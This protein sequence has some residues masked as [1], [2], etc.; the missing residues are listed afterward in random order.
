MIG[1][2]NNGW[3]VANTTLAFERAGLGSGGGSAAASA[4]LPG[5]VAG[6]LD[7]PVG[8]FVQNRRA[9]QGGAQF[10]G[11]GRMLI[12]L[13]KHGGSIDD[14]TIRQDL[15]R[16]HTLAEIGR[17]NTLRLKALKARGQDIPGFG[18]IGKLSMSDM[19]RLQRDL[20][21]RIV[22]AQGM[23]HAYDDSKRDD[24][25][26]WPLE[27]RYPGR[28]PVETDEGEGRPS[29]WNTLR[30]LRVLRWYERAVGGSPEVTAARLRGQEYLLER[31]LFR[32]RS[33]GEVIERVVVVVRPLDDVPP[34][35]AETVQRGAA[36]EQIFDVVRQREGY[37]AQH[38]VMTLPAG[39]EQD[40]ICGADDVGIVARTADQ[41]VRSPV[42][43]E[44]VHVVVA[45]QAP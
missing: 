16:L 4:A 18:N 32:R 24:D 13:A 3:A 2:L 43:T 17:Y 38:P 5:T 33:T 20:S 7:K 40:D 36:Q 19:M 42:V 31:R 39:F 28:M 45:A 37:G 11:A 6:H 26:R 30:A 8:D 35:I 25:D 14:P 1:D 44:A 27:T 34:G 12:E 9:T 10:R 21:L 22:G 15:M 41:L 29:R 23:C